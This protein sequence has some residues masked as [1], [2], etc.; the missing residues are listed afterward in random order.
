MSYQSSIFTTGGQLLSGTGYGYFD[1]PNF[2]LEK[3]LKN[4]SGILPNF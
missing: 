1:W 4:W 3:V 2:S